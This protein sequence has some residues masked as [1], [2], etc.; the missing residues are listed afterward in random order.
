MDETPEPPSPEGCP[1]A[2]VPLSN[3]GVAFI[4]AADWPMVRGHTWRRKPSS[5][6]LRFYAAA[7]A[8]GTRGRGTL[9]MHRLL[10]GLPKGD[11]RDVDHR[12]HDGLDNR[13]SVNIRPC[14]PLQNVINA[15][16]WQKATTSRF[17][18]ICWSKGHGQWKAS[19]R[20]GA[21]YLNVGLF[22]A[23]IDAA[24]AYA[25][26]AGLLHDP[27]FHCHVAIPPDLMPA[28]ERQAAIRAGVTAK[29]KA[30]TAGL[31]GK[32]GCT[33][34]YRGVRWRPDRGTWCVSVIRPDRGCMNLGRYRAES[35]AAFAYNV[36]CSVL[37]GKRSPNFIPDDQLPPADRQGEIKQAVTAKIHLL[38][39]GRKGKLGATSQRRGVYFSRNYSG[40]RKWV[41]S[42]RRGGK[43][44]TL[45]YFA[46]EQEAID[47]LEIAEDSTRKGAMTDAGVIG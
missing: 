36:A 18:G 22:D 43:R 28:P 10:L 7:V 15:R 19:I 25:V 17:K 42:I 34:V 40:S 9:F 21:R 37:G 14:S 33:S 38:N 26:A 39:L 31:K 1:W 41:A 5:D 12:N 32:A 23:E 2:A 24:F 27:Q 20:A 6:G 13:R 3:G 8:P 45:G 30:L 47:A 16:K 35:E 4:D 11:P 44:T 29:V 46:S